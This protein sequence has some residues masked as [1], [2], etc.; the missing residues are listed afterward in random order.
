MVYKDFVTA[1]KKQVHAV[2]YEQGL[3]L[4]ITVCK[5]LYPDY[6][7]F[8]LTEN[9]GDKDL[10][11]DAIQ[12]C[13]QT[14]KESIDISRINDLIAKIDTVIPDMDDF[15]NYDGSYAL[16][17]AASVYETLHFILDKD[18]IHLYHIGAHLTDTIDFKINEKEDLSDDQ[19][20][21]HPMMLEARNFLLQQTS[22]TSKDDTSN[23]TF[24]LK[25]FF[26]FKKNSRIRK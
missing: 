3:Q 16:N 15:G 24:N 8:V 22:N 21:K 25:K 20:D 5:R 17:A 26:T 23:F 10:L 18:P 4:A 12:L 7:H 2:S 13:E 1:F 6:A 11:I 14:Q 9:W 19:I